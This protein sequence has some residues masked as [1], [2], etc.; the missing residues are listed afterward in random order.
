MHAHCNRSRVRRHGWR[1]VHVEGALTPFWQ[2]RYYDRYM[3]DYDEFA[4]K[5]RYIHRNPVRRGLCSLPEQWLW[6]SFRHYWNGADV[7][8]DIESEWTTRTR[9][10]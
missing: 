5:L 1:G 6:S 8:V 3:R 9:Q 2:I 4:E 10:L 7:G